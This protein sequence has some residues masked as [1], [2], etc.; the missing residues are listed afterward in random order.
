[1]MMLLVLFQIQFR[2]HQHSARKS[3]NKQRIKER[4]RALFHFDDY[5][6]FLQG[7]MLLFSIS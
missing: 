4:W 7:D 5:L 3:I 1:M 6:N 2:N